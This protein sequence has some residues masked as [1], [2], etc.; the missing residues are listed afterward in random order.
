M[1]KFCNKYFKAFP[2]AWCAKTYKFFLLGNDHLYALHPKNGKIKDFKRKYESKLLKM[3]EI[4]LS[5]NKKYS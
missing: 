4:A 3:I 1:I 2:Y 5:K